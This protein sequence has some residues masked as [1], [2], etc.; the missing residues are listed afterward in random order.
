MV[1]EMSFDLESEDPISLIMVAKRFGTHV[2]T[3]LRWHL[4]GTKSPNGEVVHLEARRVGRAWWSSWPAVQRFSDRLTPDVDR[5]LKLIPR[6]PT[7][8]QRDNTRAREAL[9][10]A[11]F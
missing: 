5:Q 11:G 9:T 1:C 8:R 2:S 10:A 4:K 7:R 3:V 6:T